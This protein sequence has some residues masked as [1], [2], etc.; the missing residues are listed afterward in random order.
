MIKG[1][2]ISS[3]HEGPEDRKK[4][5]ENYRE[6]FGHSGSKIEECDR[7]HYKQ[8]DSGR[9]FHFKQFDPYYHWG[10]GKIVTGKR[11]LQR[12]LNAIGAVEAG[13]ATYDEFRRESIKKS[14][15]KT[16]DE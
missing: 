13:G 2:M 11:D 4:Y 12:K 15:S 3:A 14:G 5:A 1:E 7:Q 9:V 16:W 10:I 8:Y 6:I